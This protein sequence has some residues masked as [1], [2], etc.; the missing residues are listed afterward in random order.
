MRMILMGTPSFVIPIF[1]KL[2]DSHE[3]EA[4]FTRAPKPA[5]RKKILTKSPVHEWAQM[6]GISVYTSIREFDKLSILGTRF[7]IIV[8]AY[9]VILRENVLNAAPCINIH[10]SDLPKYRGAS[11][12]STAIYNGET[13]SAVCLMQV[14]PEVDA[15]DVF[16]RRK[17][18]IRENE[19]VRDIEKKIGSIGA[20]MILEYLSAPEKY[21]PQPQSGEP[22]FTRKWTSGDEWIDWSRSPEQIHNQI[23][24]LG[25]GRAIIN[26]AEV[27][28]LETRLS[29]GAASSE[30]EGARPAALEF[31]RVQPAG[32]KPMSWNDFI[33][34]QRGKIEFGER[35]TQKEN[36]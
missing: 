1:D 7:S 31:I 16:M 36:K 9:G 17:F 2:A 5:G 19:S 23:R 35:A 24:A 33:N 34:G 6:R 25:A 30:R 28:I 10:P 32:K 11:P 12:I 14:S 8:A 27:K 22:T 4:V 21:P 20:E 15:G 3:I 29:R 13:E 26:N 18:A